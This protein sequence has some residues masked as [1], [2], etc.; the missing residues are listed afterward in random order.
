LL[1]H[2]YTLVANICISF[3]A[4]YTFFIFILLIFIICLIWQMKCQYLSLI[5]RPDLWRK[6]LSVYRNTSFSI[7]LPFKNTS[8][9]QY[10]YPLKLFIWKLVRVD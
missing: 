7:K 5:C 4:F 8:L 1:R 10:A 9:S 2:P 3:H 6:T